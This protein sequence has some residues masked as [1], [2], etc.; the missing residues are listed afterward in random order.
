MTKV[1]AAVATVHAAGIMHRDLKP[2]DIFLVATAHGGVEPVL[3][4]FGI[5]KLKAAGLVVGEKSQLTGAGELLG[6]PC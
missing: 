6:T 1:M 2:E 5:C 3:L 4:D